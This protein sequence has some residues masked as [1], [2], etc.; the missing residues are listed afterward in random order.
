MDPFCVVEAHLALARDSLARD[1]TEGLEPF[2]K[3]GEIRPGRAHGGSEHL[4]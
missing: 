1:D 4:G 2:E 3:V